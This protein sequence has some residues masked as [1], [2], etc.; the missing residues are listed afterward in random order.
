MVVMNIEPTCDRLSWPSDKGGESG[1]T[2]LVMCFP[3]P[4]EK[5]IADWR[6]IK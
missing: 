4:W 5:L 1:R 3:L 6:A 2:L